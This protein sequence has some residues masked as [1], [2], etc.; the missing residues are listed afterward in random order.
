MIEMEQHL[1]QITANLQPVRIGIITAIGQNH[2]RARLAQLIAHVASHKAGGTEHGG[3]DAIEAAASACAAL[4]GSQI[5]GLQRTW[6]ISIWWS[7]GGTIAAQAHHT[8]DTAAVMLCK[9]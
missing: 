1:T 6:R 5:C 8:H 7:G 9:I 3:D 4:H 2:L